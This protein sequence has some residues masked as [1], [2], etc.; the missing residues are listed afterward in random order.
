MCYLPLKEYDKTQFSR[1]FSSHSFLGHTRNLPTRE[2]V[3]IP[4]K[5]EKNEEPGSGAGRMEA[6]SFPLHLLAFHG[7][8]Q[9]AATFKGQLKTS[10]LCGP[11]LAPVCRQTWANSGLQRRL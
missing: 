9:D 10:I 2:D 5:N 7:F 3:S 4:G 11:E 6:P 1:L 8:F